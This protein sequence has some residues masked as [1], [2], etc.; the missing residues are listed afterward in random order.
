MV[1]TARLTQT[2][3]DFLIARPARL[4]GTSSRWRGIKNVLGYNMVIYN[5]GSTVNLYQHP[6]KNNATSVIDEFFAARV[7]R[8][9]IKISRMPCGQKGFK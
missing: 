5:F 3:A 7:S 9:P 6:N 8:L 2:V 1:L 4:K